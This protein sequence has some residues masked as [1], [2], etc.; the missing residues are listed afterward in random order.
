MELEKPLTAE[1]YN[2]I[3]EKASAGKYKGLLG[4]TTEPIVSSD[5]IG[6]PHSGV[7]DAKATL[8][9]NN[10]MVKSIIWYDNGW[11]YAY[12]L[13]ETAKKMAGLIGSGEV[14]S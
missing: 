6:N 13:L 1:E 10:G 8:S 2:A 7:I 12:R 14:K 9:L 11:A 5:V 4:Y 3:F